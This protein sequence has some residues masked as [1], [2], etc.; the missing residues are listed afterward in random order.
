MLLAL[1][2]DEGVGQ[3]NGMRLPRCLV[4]LGKSRTLLLWKSWWEMDQ[5]QP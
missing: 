1:G 4:A 2:P 3:F 5:K